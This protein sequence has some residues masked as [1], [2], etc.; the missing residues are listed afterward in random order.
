MD[1]IDL[2]ESEQQPQRGLWHWLWR[3]SHR[4]FLLGLPVGALLAFVI[5]VGFTAGV[6]HPAL[7]YSESD[8]FCTSCHEMQIPYAQFQH[9]FHYSNEFGIRPTCADCHVPPGLGP[10]LLAHLEASRDAWGHLTGIIN[11]PAK[12]EQN[13]LRMAQIVWKD[14]KE[15][16]SVTC[17]RCHSFAAMA[18]DKQSREAAKHHSPEYI[19]KTGKTCIDCHKGVAHELPTEM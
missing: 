9:S 4:W 7:E 3:P 17:R 8:A 11:T 2:S 14:L 6:L 13:K 5:G 12:F 16:D 18:L 19:A 1:K 10:G 15:N